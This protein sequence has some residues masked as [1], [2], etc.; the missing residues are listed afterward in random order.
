MYIQF[1]KDIE[2]ND[3][4]LNHKNT[5]SENM[6]LNSIREAIKAGSSAEIETKRRD[7]YVNKLKTCLVLL[8][9]C[10]NSDSSKNF[11]TSQFAGQMGRQGGA[12]KLDDK[13]QFCKAVHL[14]NGKSSNSLNY[15]PKFA[16]LNERC[17]K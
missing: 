8:Q 17:S 5:I 10:Q 9:K 1:I 4:L 2:E 7:F 15:C 16:E 11:T 6:D 3:I 13:C 14:K 12:S